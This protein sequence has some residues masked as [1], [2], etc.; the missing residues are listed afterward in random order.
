MVRVLAAGI[1]VRVTG[2][3]RIEFLG[4]HS[5]TDAVRIL[6]SC[7]ICYVPYW[8]DEA[9]RPGVELSFPNKVS[10]YLAAGRPILYHG[11]RRG[12]PTRFLE[13]WPVGVACHSLEVQ[14]IVETL[15]T[16]AIDE[17]FHACAATAIPHVLRE[18]L[19]LHVFRRRF[20]EFLGVSEAVLAP[21]TP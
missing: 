1:D 4:W 11:P 12:T 7:D 2:P 13:R 15:A 16:A 9:F 3:A 14:P 19:G 8:F 5:T 17:T 6:A 21:A 18:E 10:L 20:A